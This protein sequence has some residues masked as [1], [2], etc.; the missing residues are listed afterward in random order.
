MRRLAPELGIVAPDFL[1]DE[2]LADEIHALLEQNLEALGAA[3]G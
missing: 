3:G 2:A 1:F